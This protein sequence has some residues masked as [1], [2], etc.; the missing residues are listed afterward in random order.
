MPEYLFIKPLEALIARGNHLFGAAGDHSEALMPPWPSTFS[1]ALRTRMLADRR[2]SLARY[3]EGTLEDAEL[4]RVLGTPSEPGEFRLSFLG[5]AKAGEGRSVLCP[6]PADL[7]VH[8]VEDGYEAT[9]LEPVL[10]TSGVL[11]SVALRAIPSLLSTR[12]EKAATGL[13]LDADGIEAYVR[14][15]TPQP[16]SLR[17]QR[18]L[19]QSELRLGIALDEARRTAAKGMLYTSDAVHLGRDVGFVVGVTN[20]SELLPQDGLLRLGGDGRGAKVERC[21]PVIRPWEHV[22]DTP[23]FR[24]VLTTPGMFPDGSWPPGLIDENGRRILRFRGLEAE[25]VAASV[26]RFQVVSGWNLATQAP[27]PARRAVAT[28]TVYWLKVL[29]P[30]RSALAE[31]VA[32]GL[33]PLLIEHRGGSADTN[34]IGGL[35][36]ADRQ[37]RAEGFGNVLLGD[38]ESKF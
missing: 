12:Q 5:L 22:P 23:G 35:A 31:L 19:W 17:R 24:M 6:L 18:D 32:E 10:P 16:A 26:P 2:V 28:G 20:V 34:M 38:W 25:L 1:G 30:D 29:R 4:R 14:H 36:P 11:T 3:A 27:K 7:V 8:R 13:W 21:E 33:W 37:R 15:A 9:F